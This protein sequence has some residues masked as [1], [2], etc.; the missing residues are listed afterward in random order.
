MRK[1]QT[2][3]Y[4]LKFLALASTIIIILAACFLI[5]PYIQQQNYNNLDKPITANWKDSS[6]A[7]R[8]YKILQNAFYTQKTK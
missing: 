4:R 3:K 6:T 5:I 2:L 7:T 1:E 8:D